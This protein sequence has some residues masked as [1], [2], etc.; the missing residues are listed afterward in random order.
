MSFDKA[1]TNDCPI[2]AAI[3]FILDRLN[4][5]IN[6]SADSRRQRTAKKITDMKVWVTSGATGRSFFLI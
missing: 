3:L 2:T 6:V 1:R 4:S 5:A